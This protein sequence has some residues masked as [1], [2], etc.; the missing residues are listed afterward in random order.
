MVQLIEK[1]CFALIEG[2][3]SNFFENRFVFYFDEN[4]FELLIEFRHM[5]LFSICL[6]FLRCVRSCDK[7]PNYCWLCSRVRKIFS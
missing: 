5:S 2:I 6:H 4:Y 7:K 1:N 3:Y